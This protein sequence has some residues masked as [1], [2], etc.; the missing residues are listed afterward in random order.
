[1]IGEDLRALRKRL[2]L[3]QAEFAEKIGRKRNQVNAY[4]AGREKIPASIQ[5]LCGFMEKEAPCPTS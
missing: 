2:G 4:E 3:T 1:M 5:I